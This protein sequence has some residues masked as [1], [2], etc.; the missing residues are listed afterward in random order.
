MELLYADDLVL[1]TE[2]KELLLE[3]LGKWKRGMEMK[4]FRVNASKTK[5]MRCQVNKVQVEV[6]G[7]DPCSVCRKL[8]GI[9][10]C[11]RTVT[12]G[13][14]KSVVVYQES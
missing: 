2:T 13:F 6:S 14:I 4:G 11:A 1:A 3:E 7:K 8:V 10:S 9:R 12:V 5:V